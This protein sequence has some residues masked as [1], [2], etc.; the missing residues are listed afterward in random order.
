MD[1][2][3]SVI[4]GMMIAMIVIVLVE[5]RKARKKIA[6]YLVS[7]YLKASHEERIAN[8]DENDDVTWRICA[9]ECDV[10]FNAIVDLGVHREL[11]KTIDKLS[12]QEKD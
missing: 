10:L 5:R 6:E 12:E 3:N 9:A 8:A 4:I 11:M 7:E 1:Y 2:I